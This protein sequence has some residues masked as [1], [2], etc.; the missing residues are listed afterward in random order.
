L[1]WAGVRDA[2]DFVGQAPQS[3]FG[4]PQRG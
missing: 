3:R 2:L 4:I 1:P